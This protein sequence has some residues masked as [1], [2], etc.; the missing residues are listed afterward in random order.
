M[1]GVQKASCRSLGRG[2]GGAIVLTLLLPLLMSNILPRLLT[3]A[4]RLL[5]PMKQPVHNT[6]QPLQEA[7]CFSN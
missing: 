3:L 5:F 6:R 2:W 7:E 1:Q 4:Q